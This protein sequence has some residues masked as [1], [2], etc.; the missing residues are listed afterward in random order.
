MVASQIEADTHFCWL[1]FA[2]PV[3]LSVGDLEAKLGLG[4]QVSAE[5]RARPA[6][7]S[8]CLFASDAFVAV[9]APL[10]DHLSWMFTQCRDHFGCIAE[11]ASAPDHDVSLF[12]MRQTDQTGSYFEFDTTMLGPF[13]NSGVRLTIKFEYYG[14]EVEA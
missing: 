6:S 13:I 14:A 11:F 3:S 8:P 7:P 9:D 1:R 4:G 10:E 12:L 5:A 2:S